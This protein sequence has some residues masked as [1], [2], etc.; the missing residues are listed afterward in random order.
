MNKSHTTIN[1]KHVGTTKEGQ[2]RRFD[3]HG[4]WGG[5]DLIILRTTKLGGGVKN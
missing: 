2:E 5:R 3:R 4:A 1:K